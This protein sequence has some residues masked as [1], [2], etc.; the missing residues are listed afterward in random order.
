LL[1]QEI[2]TRVFS[3]TAFMVGGLQREKAKVR[4]GKKRKANDNGQ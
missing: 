2:E 1:A 4:G 3:P